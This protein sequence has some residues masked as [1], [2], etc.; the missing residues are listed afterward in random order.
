M[1]NLNFP[2]KNPL[3]SWVYKNWKLVE[4]SSESRKATNINIPAHSLIN[5]CAFLFLCLQRNSYMSVFTTAIHADIIISFHTKFQIITCRFGNH[6]YFQQLTNA[7]YLLWQKYAV[8]IIPQTPPNSRIWVWVIFSRFLANFCPK[9]P[10]NDQNFIW[11]L[12]LTRWN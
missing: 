2:A 12:H 4:N 3:K 8:G 5:Y 7:C 6:Y 10:S 11:R 9:N 1:K